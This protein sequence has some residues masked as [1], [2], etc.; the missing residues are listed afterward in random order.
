MGGLIG[1]I[2]GI[3]GRVIGFVSFVST[4][5]LFRTTALLVNAFI[6][7]LCLLSNALSLCSKRFLS[8]SARNLFSLSAFT[9]ILRISDKTDCGVESIGE[10]SSFLTLSNLVGRIFSLTFFNCSLVKDLAPSAIINSISPASKSSLNVVGSILR[11]LPGLD[12]C[13][14]SWRYVFLFKLIYHFF[15][16]FIFSFIL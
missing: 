8:K 15:S 14:K 9:I 16:K 6:S 11:M 2:G 10:I 7:S 3:G 4:F 5:S 12:V 13:C 1:G